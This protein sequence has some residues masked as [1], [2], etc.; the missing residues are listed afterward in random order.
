MKRIFI[1]LLALLLLPMPTRAEEAPT[2]IHTAD[3][4]LAIAN[5]PSGSYILM[6][7]LDMTGVEWESPD[8]SGSFDGNGHAILNLTLSS[9][10]SALA[11]TYD[12]NAKAY[13]TACA[14][15][16][17]TMT[18]AQV[19]DLRLVNVRGVIESDMPCFVGG[20]AGY[21]DNSTVENCQISGT[22]ELR[23]HDRMFGM[24]GIAGYGTGEIAGC[25]TNMTLICVDTDAAT[26][27][28]Q[29]LGG[30]YGAGFI[31]V[32]DCQ[33][34]LDAYISEHGYVHSG[35][36]TGMFLYYPL[37]DGQTGRIRNN[38]V[39]GKITFFEDNSDRRAY[40]DPFIGEIMVFS[41]FYLDGN[42]HDF[43]ED[44]QRDYTRELRPEMCE[45]PVYTQTVT[46]GACTD[47]GCTTYTC[48]GCGYSYTDHYTLPVHTLT[49]WVTLEDATEEAEGLAESACDLCGEKFR[50]VV[51]KLPPSPSETDSPVT[52]APTD[53]PA[54]EQA[55][56]VAPGFPLIEV[57]LS[58]GG[59]AA[60]GLTVILLRPKKKGKFQSK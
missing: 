4:L 48:Q 18:D 19:K 32:T 47:F 35:G 36:I 56:E 21:L 8:F 39:A 45:N 41:A 26:K 44:E 59:L 2:E 57:I 52:E 9:T 49:K 60:A 16:F 5:D 29:F 54:P 31:Q 53:S 38:H 22:L 23:A 15:F 17:A 10:G 34:R 28:E 27:D 7:D 50:R 30:A 37:G 20:I 14:G 40:C 25:N 13:Q 1:L 3:Q 33:I 12:G 51:E 42:T 11:D 46:E 55:Q 6:A 58:V 43:T 24:G